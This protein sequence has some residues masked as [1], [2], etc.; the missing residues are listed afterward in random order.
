M[1]VV[2]SSDPGRGERLRL[3]GTMATGSRRREQKVYVEGRVCESEGC[4][5]VL[6]RY[7]RSTRCWQH[8]PG[9]AYIPV[10]GRRPTEVPIQDLTL[11]G[12]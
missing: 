11:L 2:V 9:R 1:D 12:A 6:S 10:R 3:S 5:T 8:E 4:S 7:N